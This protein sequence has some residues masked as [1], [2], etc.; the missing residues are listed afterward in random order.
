MKSDVQNKVVT[1]AATA[2]LDRG[3]TQAVALTTACAS[4]HR[5]VPHAGDRF[6]LAVADPKLEQL[7]TRLEQRAVDDARR[8]QLVWQVT[9]NVSR[10]E[11]VQHRSRMRPF[12]VQS[13]V[14]RLRLSVERCTKAV[15]IAVEVT[16]D[17]WLERCRPDD[18]SACLR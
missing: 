15:D 17:K 5:D 18:G 7:V 13:C 6:T 11:M 12:L 14:D 3:A 10:G 8:Q 2:R 1:K 16:L 9:D 4:F